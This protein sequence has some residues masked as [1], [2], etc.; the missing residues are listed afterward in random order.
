[1]KQNSSWSTVINA[2]CS[3]VKTP[4]SQ[5]TLRESYSGQIDSPGCWIPRVRYTKVLNVN[6]ITA[7]LCIL[8]VINNF[9]LDVGD[10]V[11]FGALDMSPGKRLLGKYF[12]ILL[13]QFLTFMKLLHIYFISKYV[14]HSVHNSTT[15]LSLKSFIS[16][17]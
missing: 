5:Q 13:W 14:V 12:F 6:C 9:L 17:K 3:E 4:G 10:Y 15:G 2:R 1:M 7:Q 11:Y 16:C 8:Y